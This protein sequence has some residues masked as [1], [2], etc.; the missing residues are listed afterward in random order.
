[1]ILSAP[2][3]QSERELQANSI[4]IGI[5]SAYHW[6]RHGL[7]PNP[8]ALIELFYQ[9]GGLFKSF[10]YALKSNSGPVRI[11]VIGDDFLDLKLAYNLEKALENKHHNSK[12][13]VDKILVNRY[14]NTH[15]SADFTL[16]NLKELANFIKSECYDIVVCD[17]DN[18]LWKYYLGHNETIKSKSNF[19]RFGSMWPLR[20]GFLL[21]TI[22]DMFYSV[23]GIH[24]RQLFSK[25]EGTI[26]DVFKS[27]KV[28]NADLV[29]NSMTNPM[30][31]TH[32]LNKVSDYRK[33]YYYSRLFFQK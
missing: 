27:I 33:N 24:N 16:R 17:G 29:I 32:I 11:G 25:S 7:K 10:Q 14:G 15:K 9:Y 13:R 31:I 22:T 21:F 23:L 5:V 28:S 18:T 12:V 6:I 30:D 8:A 20:A 3:V 19:D 2:Q 1:M 26:E 4:N